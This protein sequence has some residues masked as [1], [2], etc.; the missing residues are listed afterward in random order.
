MARPSFS[1]LVIVIVINNR[2]N[3]Q[4]IFPNETGETA[5]RLQKGCFNKAEMLG[6]AVSRMSNSDPTLYTGS[7][8]VYYHGYVPS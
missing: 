2:K 3:V 1:Y 6:K 8:G 5:I 4:P 7:N